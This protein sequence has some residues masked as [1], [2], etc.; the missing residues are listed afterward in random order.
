MIDGLGMRGGLKLK[1][2]LYYNEIIVFYVDYVCFK[3]NNILT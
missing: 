2:G 1:L 3:D